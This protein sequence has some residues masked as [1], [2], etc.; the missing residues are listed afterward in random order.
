[1]TIAKIVH[2]MVKIAFI[3]KYAIKEMIIR[4]YY[5]KNPTTATSI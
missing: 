2:L 1:M 4:Q 3:V 5:G